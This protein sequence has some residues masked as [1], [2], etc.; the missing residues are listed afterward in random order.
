M[1]TVGINPQKT[2]DRMEYLRLLTEGLEAQG[3][4]IEANIH[5]LTVC[6]VRD[7]VGQ[8]QIFPN[9]EM[10]RIRDDRDQQY[11]KGVIVFTNTDEAL[12]L[13]REWLGDNPPPAKY[14]R[15]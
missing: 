2:F 7:G 13:V 6:A 15:R 12:A 11:P 14:P 8:V 3:L 1:E 4:E 5:S 9:G 10:E